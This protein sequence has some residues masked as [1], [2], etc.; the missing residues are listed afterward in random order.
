[1]KKVCDLS[2]EKYCITMQVYQERIYE[3]THFVMV[4]DKTFAK[5]FLKYIVI[6][7]IDDGL[8]MSKFSSQYTIKM[9]GYQK[10]NI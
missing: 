9:R 6:Y 8:K 2:T 3:T 7:V 1:M 10:E 4:T 5:Y